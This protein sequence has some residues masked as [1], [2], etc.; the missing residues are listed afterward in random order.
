MR[1]KLYKLSWNSLKWLMLSGFLVLII[2]C[3]FWI[4]DLRINLTPSMPLGIWRETKELEKGSFIAF[5]L[6][7]DNLLSSMIETR[8]YLPR[9]RCSDGFAPLLKQVVATSGDK[10]EISKDAVSVN[11]KTFYHSAT[12][13][14]DSKGRPMQ[15]ILRGRYIVSD[16]E[17]WVLA[18]DHPRSL[19]S[20]YFGGIPKSSIT[21]GMKPVLIFYRYHF[22]HFDDN[23][24]IH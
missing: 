19:D 5:C 17:Y 22:D 13:S 23:S 8:E 4:F 12:L 21:H 14:T 6:P 11:G 10:I 3:I 9:G 16:N 2:F 20:R 18:T 1:I 7:K 15:Y 24:G